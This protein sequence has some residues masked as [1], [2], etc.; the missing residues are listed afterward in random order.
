MQV[1]FQTVLFDSEDYRFAVVVEETLVIVTAKGEIELEFDSE[2][3]ALAGQLE[4]GEVL[5]AAKDTNIT[6]VLQDAANTV[7]NI[8]SNLFD[9]TGTYATEKT[10]NVDKRVTDMISCLDEVLKDTFTKP[11]T[12]NKTTPT[13]AEDVFGTSRTKRT[14]DSDS[15]V[16]T[17]SDDELREIISTKSDQIFSSNRQVQSLMENLRKFHIEYEIQKAIDV[18]KEM[19]FKVARENDDLTVNEVFSLLLQ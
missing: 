9:K 2:K 19:V 15:V 8:V 12:A 13:D 3:D 11:K 1:Q 4:L 16:N 18:H 14:V 17:L 7:S 10:N 5:N 6:S